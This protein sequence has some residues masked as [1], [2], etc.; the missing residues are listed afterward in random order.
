ASGL[1][2][3]TKRP[4][5]EVLEDFLRVIDE[6]YSA[7]NYFDRCLRLSK[8]LEIKPRFKPTWRT[9]LGYAGAFLKL[10]VCLGLRP[11]TC[12]YFWRNLFAVLLTHPAAAE[13]VVNLMAMYLHFGP[14][15][16]FI[17]RLTEEKIRELS[18]AGTQVSES[19]RP[20]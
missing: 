2:F 1:N 12:Y 4:R 3:I 13:T 7:K 17:T 19:A 11:S 14:H 9:K 18:P 15:A 6:T 16:K 5:A 8:E 20:T 10:A